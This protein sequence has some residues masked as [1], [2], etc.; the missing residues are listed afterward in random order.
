MLKFSAKYDKM[1]EKKQFGT[2][3][4]LIYVTAVKGKNVYMMTLARYLHLLRCKR[5]LTY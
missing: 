4:A 2:V 3:I 1:A 5:S